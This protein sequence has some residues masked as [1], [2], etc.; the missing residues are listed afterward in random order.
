MRGAAAILAALAAS[1]TLAWG[2]GGEETVEAAMGGDRF[3][4][5]GTVTRTQP[6]GGDLIAAGGTLEL[7]APVSGDAL[8]AGGNVRVGGS[9]SQNLYAAGGRVNIDGAVARNARIAGGKVH[10]GSGSAITGNLTVAGGTV[11]IEGTVGG[12]VQASGGDITIDGPVQGDVAV[13]GGRLSLGPRAKIGGNLSY[14]SGEEVVLDPAAVV[15]GRIERLNAPP[16]ATSVSSPHTVSFHGGW[17]WSAGL[18]VLAALFAAAVPPASMR[19]SEE[20]R[21]HPGSALL[22]GF[23]ALV[24]IPAAVL[25]LLITVIGI[26]LAMVVLLAYVI[27]LVVG[28]VATAV[29]AGDAAVKRWRPAD[30][31]RSS[32]RVLAAVAAMLI[33]T[34]L[35]RIPIAGSVVVFFATLLG[36]GALVM[37]MRRRPQ[38]TAAAPAA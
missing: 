36:L 1:A 31:E 34:L 24:C 19:V 37:A 30:A 17:I 33:L 11:A 3:L 22:F 15:T 4:A 35:G 2:A 13:N 27:L 14:R 12:Y 7:D 21:T 10:I 18:L 28:Y 16:A 38:A 8:A 32:W 6:V 25:I 23:I 9:V 26:P 5:G 20:A 29:A